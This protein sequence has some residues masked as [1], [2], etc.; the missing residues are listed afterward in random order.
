MIIV[1][2]T[3]CLLVGFL[4]IKCHKLKYEKMKKKLILWES[5]DNCFENLPTVCSLFILDTIN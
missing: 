4:N 1:L 3:H 5:G 2:K